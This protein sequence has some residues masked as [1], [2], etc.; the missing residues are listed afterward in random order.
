MERQQSLANQ[1]AFTSHAE[2]VRD[3]RRFLIFVTEAS[4]PSRQLDAVE[5][6]E[7]QV[8][9]GVQKTNRL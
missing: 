7:T 9:C 8:R 1:L 6:A 4:V 5:S 3:R 2:E